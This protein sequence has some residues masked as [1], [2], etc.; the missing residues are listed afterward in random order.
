MDTFWYLW[1]T[2]LGI[3][4][5]TTPLKSL[6]YDPIMHAIK[7]N[8]LYLQEGRAFNTGIFC[9]VRSCKG[10]MKLRFIFKKKASWSWSSPILYYYY[11]HQHHHHHH[12]QQHSS[13]SIISGLVTQAFHLP[14]AIQNWPLHSCM[15]YFFFGTGRTL[16][17]DYPTRWMTEEM[18]FT[19][20]WFVMC[21]VS[22]SIVLPSKITRWLNLTQQTCEWKLLRNIRYVSQCEDTPSIKM[23]DLLNSP[24]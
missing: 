21:V 4:S 11:H 6:H 23:H 2:C 15:F 5:F 17:W 1:S 10:L 12:H 20:S 18:W 22:H 8:D 13:S 14:N 16:F 7:F 9:C 24:S 3:G 19:H